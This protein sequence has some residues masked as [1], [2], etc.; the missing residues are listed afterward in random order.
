MLVGLLDLGFRCL[1]VE[2]LG[3]IQ[4]QGDPGPVDAKWSGVPADNADTAA[5]PRVAD[6]KVRNPVVIHVADVGQALAKVA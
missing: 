4:G 3:S 2:G 5:A 1:E 6:R